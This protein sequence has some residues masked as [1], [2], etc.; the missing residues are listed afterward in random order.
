MLIKQ[1]CLK[2]RSEITAF[3]ILKDDTV[4]FST[5]VHGAKI[6]SSQS[7]S[8]SKNLSLDLLGHKTTAV[9][10]SKDYDLLAFANA[11][12]IY[13]INTQNKELVQSI[14][15]NDGIIDIIHFIPNSKYLVTGTINGRVMQYRYD[16]CS[17]LSRLGSFG[18]TG[19]RTYGKIKKNYVSAF[20]SNKEYFAFSGYGGVITILKTHSYANKQSVKESQSRINTLCFLD[21]HTLVSGNADGLIQIYSLKNLNAPKSVSTPFLNIR[22]IILM[23]NPKFFLVVAEARNAIVIDSSAAKVVSLNYLNFKENISRV[24]LGNDN[25]LLV[26]L[27]NKQ[28]FKVALPTT[29][30]LQAFVVN[31][32][33]DKAYELVQ[34]DPTLK[35]SREYKRLEAIFQNLCTQAISALIHSNVTQARKLLDQFNQTP[36]KKDEINEI[37]IAFEHYPRFKTL[38]LEK[39]LSLSYAMVQKHPALKQTAQY[40]KMQEAFKETFSFAQKQILMGRNDIAK[41]ILSVY[42]TVISKKPLLKLVLNHNEDF[43]DFLKATATKD[44]EKINNLLK[45]NTLFSELPTYVAIKDFTQHSINNIQNT[46]NKGE[47][48]NAIIQIKKIVNAPT[49][50]HELQELY[51]TCQLIKK[52]QKEY[53]KNDLKTCYEIIDSSLSLDSLELSHVLEKHWAKLMNECEDHALKG[54]I[55]SVKKILGELMRITSRANKIGDLIRVS[56]HAKIKILIAK[57]ISKSAENIIYSYVDIFGPDNEILIIMKNY[58]KKFEKKLAITINQDQRVSRDNWLNSTLIMC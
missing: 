33:L 17:H 5:R 8:V 11:N 6:F 42:A 4:A 58:E 29:K 25:N 53:E 31:N 54:D 36:S 2:T 43:I 45:K 39:K 22:G 32:K 24:A 3:S 51:K 1:E 18:H 55:K 23:P 19:I 14:S 40:K 16:G 21:E 44:F 48:D 27:D 15:T 37:F 9:A 57:K 46:I 35:D 30:E 41:E 28:I 34:N 56:F 13:V 38:Y 47:V 50:I 10:F 20:A 7:C 52:L 12:V 49:I 26:V